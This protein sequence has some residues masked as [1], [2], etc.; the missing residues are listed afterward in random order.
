LPGILTG[1][2]TQAEND[3][4]APKQPEFVAFINGGGAVLGFS[5]TGLTNPFAYI[6]GVGAFTFAALPT[7]LPVIQVTPEGATASVSG[8]LSLC[9][10][11]DDFVAFPSYLDILA[12]YPDEFITD[13]NDSSKLIG[14]PDNGCLATQP[15]QDCKTAAIGGIQVVFPD[16]GKLEL[17]PLNPTNTLPLDNMHTVTAL[18]SLQTAGSGPFVPVDGV[19]VNFEV[20]DNHTITDS[21]VTGESPNPTGVC[22]ITYVGSIE[23]VDLI[24]GTADVAGTRTATVNKTWV[25]DGCTSTN[26][27]KKGKKSKKKNSDKCGG[28]ELVRL[29]CKGSGTGLMVEVTTKIK[30][31]MVSVPGSKFPVTGFDDPFVIN[32]STLPKGKLG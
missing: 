10:W 31:G 6:G 20:T 29:T 27:K 28:I 23:G 17:T 14:D 19:T 2:L 11:H 25:D 15:T 3:A 9:C 24:T 30:G 1:G 5:N 16:V 21:C 7:Q 4:L 32:A 8:S 13:P 26:M 18:A 12:V 22:T